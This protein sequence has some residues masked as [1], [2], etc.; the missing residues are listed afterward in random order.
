MINPITMSAVLSSSDFFF[1]SPET[2]NSVMFRFLQFGQTALSVK[3][4]IGV[5]PQFFYWILLDLKT[6]QCLDSLGF[7]V[8]VLLGYP[9]EC[10][11]YLQHHPLRIVSFGV[12]VDIQG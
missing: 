2:C 6:F 10:H 5:P 9:I 11:S 7:F 3:T 8:V 12:Y 4:L 1:E